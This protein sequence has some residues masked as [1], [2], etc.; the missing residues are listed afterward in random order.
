MSE[1]RRI[2]CHV[3]YHPS[4]IAEGFDRYLTTTHNQTNFRAPAYHDLSALSAVMQASGVDLALLIPNAWLIRALASLGG[5]MHHNTERYNRSLSEDLEAQGGGRYVGAAAVDPLGG[6]EEIAQLERSLELPHLGAIGLLTSYE[7]VTLDDPRFEAI[8]EVAQEHDVP[9]TVHPAGAWPGWHES[10]R[11]DTSF[12]VS[13]VGFMLGDALAIF[14]LASAG[15]FDRHPEVRFMFGQLGGTA[16]FYCGRWN[17]QVRTAARRQRVGPSKML[18][19]YL[20]HLWLD[21]HTQDRHAIALV[22]AEAGEHTIV[23]G[24]DYP[25]TEPENGVDYALAELNALQLAPASR[26]KIERD[27]A[28]ALLGERVAHSR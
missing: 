16:P 7:D 4:A 8:W 26:Q 27:N 9:V 3:H 14:R 24:G 11:L 1:I 12:L 15:V 17:N 2:D 21:T 5:P 22:M 10:L 19:D 13:G 28:L 6:A 18:N 25:V 23:L 20:S